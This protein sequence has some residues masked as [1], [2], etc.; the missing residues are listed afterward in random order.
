MNQERIR[1]ANYRRPVTAPAGGATATSPCLR[2]DELASFLPGILPYVETPAL[3]TG[4]LPNGETLTYTLLES[5]MILPTL[6]WRA[7]VPHRG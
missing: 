4:Q 1:L 5:S 6:P 3:T 2:G 7:S